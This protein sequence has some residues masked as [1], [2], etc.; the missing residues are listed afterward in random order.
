MGFG[1]VIWIVWDMIWVDKEL[2]VFFGDVILDVDFEKVIK[3]FDFC[4]CVKKVDD[5]CKFGVVEYG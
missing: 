4:L 3:C 5:F 1:Y 2:V